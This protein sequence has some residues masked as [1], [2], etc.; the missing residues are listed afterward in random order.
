VQT[1]PR[2][3]PESLV[4]WRRRS[5][6]NS[7][8]GYS[9]GQRCSGVRWKFQLW[10]FHKFREIFEIFHGTILKV[11]LINWTSLSLRELWSTDIT[12]EWFSYYSMEKINHCNQ[13]NHYDYLSNKPVLNIMSHV[14]KYF[15]INSRE[16][17]LE[18]LPLVVVAVLLVQKKSWN[19]AWNFKWNCHWISHCEKISWNFTSLYNG[20]TKYTWDGQILRLSINN[21]V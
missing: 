6:W 19:F 12:Y 11:S 2:D 7:N 3:S 9:N 14:D 5:F 1:T 13:S 21:Q 10:K 17:P 15:C 18:K 4:F 20:L 8:G 16:T